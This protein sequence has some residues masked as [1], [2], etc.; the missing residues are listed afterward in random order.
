M[1]WDEL[2]PE[3]I[4]FK[5]EMALYSYAEFK[6]G[7]IMEIIY[8]LCDGSPGDFNAA[9]QMDLIE[10]LQFLLLKQKNIFSEWYAQKRIEEFRELD[11]Q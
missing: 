2:E 8:N 10:A 3:I 1:G 9:L 11:N 6:P 5:N 7:G 4:N